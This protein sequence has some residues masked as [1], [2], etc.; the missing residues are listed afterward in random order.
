MRKFLPV[1]G[2][3]IIS[4][5]V[6]RAGP[7]SIYG[8]ALQA[9]MPLLAAAA[10]VF[11]AIAILQSFKWR[12][13]LMMQKFD[14]PF[15][16]I[17]KLYM[18]GVFYGAF[19][20]AKLGTLMRAPYLSRKTGRDMSECMSN[21]VIDKALGLAT[22]F[23]L[24]S[25]GSLFLIRRVSG[26]AL[27]VVPAA[28]LFVTALALFTNRELSR[29]VLSVFY[30]ILVPKSMK[31]RASQS[32]DSFYRHLPGFRKLLPVLMVTI[33]NWCVIYSQA[34]IISRAFG[35]AI[36]Y[37]YFITLLPIATIVALVPITV[38]GLGTREAALVVLFGL[39]GVPAAEVVAFS[40]TTFAVGTLLPGLFA[41]PFISGDAQ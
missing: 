38:S 33:F 31:Q 16:Y 37:H 34:F 30:R 19:T 1:I 32:F 29:K 18:V 28:V 9:D 7:A 11:I 5:I 23:I 41:L 13:I 40:L 12:M 21:I 39:F 10:L 25:A 14:L 26:L 22:L 20:P 8:A 4:Y 36:P 24:G 3:A 2:L 27:V 6:Y 15:L 35:L 17:V